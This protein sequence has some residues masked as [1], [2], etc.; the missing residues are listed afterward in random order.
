MLAP[1]MHPEPLVLDTT[2]MVSY[3][4][5]SAPLPLELTPVADIDD[6]RRATGLSDSQ[7]DNF[8]R[9]TFSTIQGIVREMQ[10]DQEQ[11]GSLMYMKRL[12]PFLLSMQH[13]SKA[14]QDAGTFVD[15]RLA[16]AYVWVSTRILV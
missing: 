13:F 3:H 11:Q 14:A 8:T 7:H 9:T 16:M 4:R 2:Q 10:T 1:K 12:E 6:F 15:L 5:T